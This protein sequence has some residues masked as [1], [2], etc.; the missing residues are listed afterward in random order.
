MRTPAAKSGQSTWVQA[1]GSQLALRFDVTREPLPDN[2]DHMLD[3]LDA[4]EEPRKP[5]A[6]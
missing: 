1:I 6:K 5:R 4:R 3:D 2:M